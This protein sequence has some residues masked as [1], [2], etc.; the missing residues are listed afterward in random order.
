MTVLETERL[1][2]RPLSFDEAPFI[3]RL[4]NEPS[5]LENIGD[6]QVRTLD[7]ANAYLMTG[8]MNSHEKYGFGLDCVELKKS[9]KPIGICG[10]LKRP[11]L[12]DV[13]IGYAFLPEFWSK[14]YAREAVSAVLA[15]TKEKFNWPR[16]A[17]IV[18]TDNK[19]S[20]RLLEGLGFRY[21]KMLC[22]PQEN[23]KVKLYILILL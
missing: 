12:E 18:N 14:G 15:D 1:Y 3:L 21:K 11:T 7:D 17:A 20:I 9:G 13:D 22:L 23:K 16:I 8:P 5:F 6:K 2:L 10:V 19:K 4:L